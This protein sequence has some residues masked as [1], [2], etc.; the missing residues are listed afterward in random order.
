[1]HHFIRQWIEDALEAMKAVLGPMEGQ[2][3]LIGGGLANLF[4]EEDEVIRYEGGGIVMLDFLYQCD[5]LARKH[6]REFKDG[7]AL[8]EHN[9]RTALEWI[10]REDITPEMALEC[11]QSAQEYQ[12]AYD[13]GSMSQTGS[14]MTSYFTEDLEMA[15]SCY[16]AK[17]VDSRKLWE[18]ARIKPGSD[19]IF[20]HVFVAY[21]DQF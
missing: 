19:T 11:L 16:L 18:F 3:I 15:C 8:A 10:R 9:A 21:Q 14:A 2:Q 1:M 12:A 20:W 7:L 17:K 6:R 13:M 5:D 4:L